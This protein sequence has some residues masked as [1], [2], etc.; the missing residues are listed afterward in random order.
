MSEARLGYILRPRLKEKRTCFRAT[1]SWESNMRLN[2]TAVTEGKLRTQPVTCFTGGQTA[3]ETLQNWVVKNTSLIS[4]DDIPKSQC[5]TPPAAILCPCHA[6]CHCPE[7][8]AHSG[9]TLPMSVLPIC[10]ARACCWA[11]WVRSKPAWST[12]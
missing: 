6:Q 7:L 1:E 9:T 4:Q 12:Q 5:T 2:T 10:G 3:T 11:I 8:K